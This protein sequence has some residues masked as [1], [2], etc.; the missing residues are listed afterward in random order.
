MIIKV[1]PPLIVLLF[2]VGCSTFTITKDE[3]VQQLKDNQNKKEVF[4]YIPVGGIASM[5]LSNTFQSN[6]I[7]KILSL[8]SDGNKVYLYPNKDT[9]L[10]ITKKSDGEI[11][12][13]YFNTAFLV[14]NKIVGLR[15]RIIQSMVR[16]V[17]LDDIEKIDIYTEMSKTDK[18]EE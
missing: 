16:E 17:D 6:Q 3:L 18:Y 14:E 13:M 12:K 15:S 2:L 4:Q 7:E 8:D 10:E 11:V 9:Q 5:F 1:T